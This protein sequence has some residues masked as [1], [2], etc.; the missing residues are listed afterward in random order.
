MTS[1]LLR[2]HKPTWTYVRIVTPANSYINTAHGKEE[3]I[4][5]MCANIIVRPKVFLE[6][7]GTHALSR[8]LM[9]EPSYRPPPSPLLHFSLQQ[10]KHCQAHTSTVILKGA[11]L[12]PL[13]DIMVGLRQTGVQQVCEREGRESC[14]NRFG[15]QWLSL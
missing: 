3:L 15:S 2:S 8:Y 13:V 10:R 4:W 7:S 14:R 1:S 5:S 6:I 11:K 12:F 9:T